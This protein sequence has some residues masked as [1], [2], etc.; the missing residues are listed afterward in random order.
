MPRIAAIVAGGAMACAALLALGEASGAG[1]KKPAAPAGPDANGPTTFLKAAPRLVR[2]RFEVAKG[3]AIVLHDLVFPKGAMAVAGPTSSGDGSIFLAFTAQARPMAI[4]AIALAVDDTGK[5][6]EATS[7]AKLPI[8]DVFVKPAN[9]VLVLGP[10]KG[11]GHVVKVPRTDGAFA[12]R[13]RTAIALE[14][15][16]T[17]KDVTLMARLG[18]RELAPIALDRIEVVGTLGLAVRGARAT[19]CGP[20]SDPTPLLVE[21][22][23]FP[24]SPQDAGA[25][26]P[27]SAKRSSTDDLCV[28]VQM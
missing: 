20:S 21:F 6:V 25:I 9:A 11:A 2:V 13:V 12:L 14:G 3:G 16:G 7:A 19:L 28:D 23:G 4:E 27:A 10:P 17:A 22:P 18:V 26:P 15:D 24:A 1:G 8:V 5:I